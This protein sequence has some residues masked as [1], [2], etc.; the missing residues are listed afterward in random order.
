M[1]RM[2]AAGTLLAVSLAGSS[3]FAQG[4]YKHH[5]WCMVDTSGSKV[6]GYDT[7]AQ[8]KAAKHGTSENCIRNT[9]PIHH[10]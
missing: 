10:R 2:I 1:I 9:A 5:P 7:L 3:A 6:C 8:C 4:S